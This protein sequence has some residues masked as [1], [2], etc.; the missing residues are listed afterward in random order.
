M[1][2]LIKSKTLPPDTVTRFCLLLSTR[3]CA[4]RILVFYEAIKT[5]NWKQKWIFPQKFRL[6]P[7]TIEFARQ[8]SRSVVCVCLLWFRTMIINRPRNRILPYFIPYFSSATDFVYVHR[9]VLND[10]SNVKE[11]RLTAGHGVRVDSYYYVRAENIDHTE[12]A[13][14]RLK[15]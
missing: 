12:G 14:I 3:L 4:L 6:C 15:I 2:P 13:C 1:P 8:E 7:S 11:S 10:I 5:R 9:C